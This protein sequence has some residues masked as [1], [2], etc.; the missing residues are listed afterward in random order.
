MNKL[1]TFLIFLSC[2]HVH[3]QTIINPH[4]VS[5]Y[6]VSSDNLLDF[7]VIAIS[8]GSAESVN[9]SF[10]ITVSQSDQL[11]G[12]FLTMYSGKHTLTKGVN[13]F[14]IGNINI[15]RKQF[16]SADF[17]NYESKMNSFPMGN[18]VYCINIVCED[19]FDRCS[20]FF[21]QENNRTECTEFTILPMSPLLLASPEDEDVLKDKRPN[22]NWI[23]PMPIGS[24]PNI[25][26][27]YTLVHLNKDQKGEDGIRRN[28]PIYK[29]DGIRAINLTYPT[30]LEDLEEGE[31]YAW[32]VSAY[33]GKILVGTSE[34][35][36]FE[37]EDEKETPSYAL[38]TKIGLESYEHLMSE[39]VIFI[40]D[41]RYKRGKVNFE[42]VS[43]R[44]ES[45]NELFEFEEDMQN[46]ISTGKN[47]LEFDLSLLLDCQEN[48]Y[49]LFKLQNTVG[50]YFYVR[51]K[52]VK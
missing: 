7:D 9:V 34:V 21:V 19:N 5:G 8:K 10:R 31:H 6:Q 33:L 25:S 29:R 35:W 40:Y 27:E 46:D 51:I 37:V 26:Y 16:A 44:D 32:Q 17:A 36:E 49:Y 47:S 39:P 2:F 52:A 42:L 13:S 20:D 24:D 3:G 15:I 4:P 28:R 30:T 43:I 14:N 18:Y 38:K 11:R 1:L 23:P 48:H 45:T 50:D 41:E 12:P 22:F